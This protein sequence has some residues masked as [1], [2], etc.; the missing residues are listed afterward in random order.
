MFNKILIANRGEIALRIIRACKELGVAPVAVY[1]DADKKA[2]HTRFADEAYYI[3]PPQPSESYLDAQKIV[4]TARISGSEAI[5]PGYGFLAQIPEFAQLCE[6]SGITFI[7]PSSQTLRLM[8]SK[9]TARETMK[10]AGIPVISGSG[11][12]VET[13]QE[14]EAL[15]RQIGY[16]ILIK[17][18]YGGGGKGLRVARNGKEIQQAMELAELEA[19]TSFGDA[20][21]YVEKLLE[22]PRHIEFQILADKHGK[23]IHLGERECSI[24]RRHQKLMEEAPSPMMNEEKRKL[25]GRRAVDAAKAVDYASAGTV[26]FL[27]DTKGDFYFLEMN[28]RLQVEH[29]VTEMV[30]GVDIVKEQIIIAAGE[31]LSYRQSN[32]SLNGHA[33]NCR[34]NAEDPI[35]DFAPSPGNVTN[36]HLPGGPGVRVDTALYIGC[37]I[38]LFYDSLIAKIAVWGRNRRETIHR[39]ANALQE[40]SIKGIETTASFL[41]QILMDK[42]YLQGRLHTCFVDDRTENLD[43]QSRNALEDAAVVTAALASY[44]NKAKTTAVI[45]SKSQKQVSFWKAAGRTRMISHG[46][47]R[48]T[49]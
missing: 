43:F 5:H 42:D 2:L 40:F 28:T 41:R 6:S 12:A 49:H 48:W 33:L 18:V 11:S 30:T 44:L 32:M 22:R 23:V 13:R 10:K 8:G 26:E 14:V 31:K 39:M 19:E 47:F 35:R 34:I 37:N 29:S 7:G 15:A 17:A 27:V 25:M 24:Q 1:S 20:Q 3:G 46:D 21:I 4:D 38:P 45:P 16:P 9:I 36:F